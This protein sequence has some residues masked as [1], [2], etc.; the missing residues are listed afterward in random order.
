VLNTA[1]VGPMFVRRRWLTTILGNAAL[2]ASLLFISGSTVASAATFTTFILEGVSFAD[3]GVAQG[4]FKYDPTS[5]TVTNVNITTTSTSSF[6]GQHYSSGMQGVLTDENLL[7]WLS[8][9]ADNSTGEVLALTV[10]GSFST[11]SPNLL[12]VGFGKSEEFCDCNAS[13]Q[14]S[15]LVASGSVDPVPLPSSLPLFVTGLVA[16]GS[17]GWRSKRRA[18]FYCRLMRRSVGFG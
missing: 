18:T 2:V 9:F 6:I 15:R 14:P 17:L 4:N 13:G 16:I 3:G 10:S 11:S 12:L 7:N 8:F 1:L 5:K